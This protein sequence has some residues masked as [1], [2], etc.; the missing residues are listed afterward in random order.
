MQFTEESNR[1]IAIYICQTRSIQLW[2]INSSRRKAMSISL[3]SRTFSVCQ[4]RKS[5]R[6]RRRRRGN[7]RKKEYLNKRLTFC[8][9]SGVPK[10]FPPWRRKPQG[11]PSNLDSLT[12]INWAISLISFTD[13]RIKNKKKTESSSETKKRISYRSVLYIYIYDSLYFPFLFFSFLLFLSS[14]FS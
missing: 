6:R 13:S 12:L 3:L 11:D 9:T 8:T 10:S 5:G 7:D 4:T 2:T 1:F 14:F